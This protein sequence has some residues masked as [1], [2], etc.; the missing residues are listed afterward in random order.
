LEACIRQA[1]R[2]KTAAQALEDLVPRRLEAKKDEDKLAIDKLACKSLYSFGLLEAYKKRCRIRIL[3]YTPENLLED[4]ATEAAKYHKALLKRQL[5]L[6]GGDYSILLE[7]KLSAEEDE[8]LIAD[9]RKQIEQLQEDDEAS[10]R[11]C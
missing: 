1:A 7:Q 5:K 4:E 10:S 11:S 6:C 2:R 3:Y 9:L 8:D